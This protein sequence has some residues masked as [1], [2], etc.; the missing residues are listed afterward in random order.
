MNYIYYSIILIYP[1]IAA[2]ILI[3]LLQN[4]VIKAIKK[5]YYLLFSVI[6]LYGGIM[7]LVLPFLNISF[8]FW[9]NYILFSIA[10]FFTFFVRAYIQTETHDIMGNLPGAKN[11]Q[12][13]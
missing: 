1:L 12:T 9:I 2:L 7:L 11:E 8:G 13:K 10:F 5:S 3:V 4:E 6:V